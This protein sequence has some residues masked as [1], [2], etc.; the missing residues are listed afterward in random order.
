MDET[1]NRRPGI[2]P[3]VATAIALLGV[4]AVLFSPAFSGEH[5]HFTEGRTVGQ[6]DALF[7]NGEWNDQDGLGQPQLFSRHGFTG[8]FQKL[9][10]LS[11]DPAAN[12]ANYHPLAS[13]FLLG[14]AAWLC[15]RQ[16]GASAIV[17]ALT[18]LAAALN[19]YFISQSFQTSAA[20]AVQGA[21][22]FAALALI[23]HPR[24]SW[25]HGLAAGALLG[26]G[27]LET[28][29][30]GLCCAIAIAAMSG[31]LGIGDENAKPFCAQRLL[32]TSALALGTLAVGWPMIQPI[33]LAPA[34][35]VGLDLLTLPVAGLFGHRMDVADNS[36]HWGSFA[37]SYYH[38]HAGALVL[39]GAVWALVNALRRES[40]FARVD[41]YRVLAFGG[42]GIMALSV[43]LGGLAGGNLL[44]FASVAL[45]VVFTLGMKGLDEW[46]SSEAHE[47]SRGF[48]GG[49][50]D[51]R[52][53]FAMFGLLTLATVGFAL[54]NGQ[55]AK[56]I[57][58]LAAQSGGVAKEEVGSLISASIFQAGMFVLF[59]FLSVVG[60]TICGLV[61]WTVRTATLGTTMLALLVTADLAPTARAFLRFDEMSAHYRE[62][63]L[64]AKLKSFGAAGRLSLLNDYRATTN[65]P[66]DVMA[67]D[68][69][70]APKPP[71]AFRFKKTEDLN[72]AKTFHAALNEY[73]NAEHMGKFN[74]LL[75][76]MLKSDDK[77]AAENAFNRL[78]KLPGGQPFLYGAQDENLLAYFMEAAVQRRSQLQ[79]HKHIA[80]FSASHYTDWA[81]HLFPQ[82]GIA[83]A[84]PG[85]YFVPIPKD[86]DR[87]E[88]VRRIIRQWELSGTRFLLCHAGNE[89]ISKLIKAEGV[90]HTLPVYRNLLDKSLDPALRRFRLVQPIHSSAASATNT[91]PVVLMEFTGALPRAKLF[92]DWMQGVDKDKTDTILYSPGFD[93]RSRVILREKGVPEPEQPS[94]AT[95][96]PEVQFDENTATRIR[97]TIPPTDFGS[98]L[99]LNDLHAPGW[100]AA[101]DGE[102]T[103][104]LRANNHARAL[105]LPASDANRTVI[106]SYQPPSPST[107]PATAIFLVTIIAAGFGV[108]LQKRAAATEPEEA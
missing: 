13:L 32:A 90:R 38:L 51:S 42:A 94:Q 66:L 23:L 98:V 73:R 85:N 54:Y 88:A 10:E 78:Q 2:A 47:A 63:P 87:T 29:D 25:P 37:D 100:A 106:F 72:L 56:L 43:M 62:N 61:N 34:E 99:M 65:A 64:T 108:F 12:F 39:L 48:G 83:L 55:S 5:V 95:N 76:A 31:A 16:L 67:C 96:L 103:A 68:D 49:G 107:P 17:C 86:T 82:Q 11:P 28:G 104:I 19:G 4:L 80:T 105:H 44:A 50:F 53:R 9:C 69:F 14:M 7:T 8:L 81:Q 52:W 60:L 45:L 79:A 40:T 18:A 24:F 84:D 3:A 71:D 20:I 35:M 58:W 46:H 75:I 70:Y 89:S 77:Q 33:G 6:W 21:A 93:P 27:V 15:A 59:L 22:L 30:M 36:Q 74:K 101:V 91:P 92:A 26:V 102:T 41:R 57:D 97:L 1:P